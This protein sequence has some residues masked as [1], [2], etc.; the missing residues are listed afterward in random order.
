MWSSLH[1][2]D[3]GIIMLTVQ[4]QGRNLNCKACIGKQEIRI[5]D[6]NKDEENNIRRCAD[7]IG[8]SIIIIWMNTSAWNFTWGSPKQSSRYQQKKSADIL[9]LT[10]SLA[11]AFDLQRRNNGLSFIYSRNATI[12]FCMSLRYSRPCYFIF[13]V[14]NSFSILIIIFFKVY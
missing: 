6:E 5:E 4:N 9:I 12:Q 13:E 11:F 7:R 2:L 3:F 10:G 8:E 14:I 1:I